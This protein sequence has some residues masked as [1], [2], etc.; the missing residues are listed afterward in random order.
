MM[1]KIER[2]CHSH[3][4]CNSLKNQKLF[5]NFLFYFWN[6]HQILNILKKNMMVIASGSPKL[7]TM[8]DF[9]RPPCKKRRFRRRFDSQHVKVHQIL[10]KSPWERFYH[11][12]SSFWENLIRK[13]SPL[14]LRKIFVVF[15]NTLTANGKYPP[16]DW[17]NLE[18]PMQMQSSEKR[19]NFSQFFV[20]FL[21]S[22][23][24]LKHF[25][26]KND[27]HT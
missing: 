2:I 23:S 21:E 19:K 5:L 20:P 3:F 25:E 22:T 9:D 11:V 10:A 12:F 6:L 8:K 13:M 14:V 24:N 15:L 18:L 26:K 17:Q 4:Q 27:G 1:F 16:K 7:Q